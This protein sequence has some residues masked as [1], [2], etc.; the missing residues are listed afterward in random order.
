MI[1]HPRLNHLEWRFSS[2]ELRSRN[3]RNLVTTLEELQGLGIAFVSLGG[4]ID[5]TTPAGKLQLHILAAL[6]ELERERIRE[7]VPEAISLYERSSHLPSG[8][9]RFDL[10]HRWSSRSGKSASLP[11]LFRLPSVG[12]NRNALVCRLD[13]ATST[14]FH[15]PSA[16]QIPSLADPIWQ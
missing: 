7:R 6:A 9:L 3:L 15:H 8:T 14:P 10:L 2:L 5:F 16:S 13:R 4:G 1:A 12:S 11:R